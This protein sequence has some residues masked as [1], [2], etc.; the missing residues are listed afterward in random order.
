[1][2]RK[3]EMDRVSRSYRRKTDTL[4]RIYDLSQ[5][6]IEAADR[7]AT[8]HLLIDAVI[9]SFSATCN[10]RECCAH[11]KAVMMLAIVLAGML[12]DITSIPT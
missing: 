4:G 10:L 2:A 8:A 7:K 6:L 3:G 11:V 1:M 9:I 12:Q 5:Q